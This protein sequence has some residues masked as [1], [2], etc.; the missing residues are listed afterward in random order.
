MSST[1]RLG[2]FIIVALLAFGFMVFLLGDKQ[3]LFSRTYRINAPFDNVAGLEEGAPVRAGGVRI[4][5]VKSIQLPHKPE[6]KI[7]VELDLAD[8]THDVIK[9]DSIATIE[10]EGLLGNKYIAVSFGSSDAEQARNG[11]TI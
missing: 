9:K 6:D 5:T 8:S 11:D 1:A 7:N 3:L 10:T 4:G 2:A